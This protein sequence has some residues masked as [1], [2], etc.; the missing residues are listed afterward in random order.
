MILYYFIHIDQTKNNFKIQLC[1]LYLFSVWRYD[2]PYEMV[3][4]RRHGVNLV[5]LGY[6]YRRKASFTNTVNW[7]CSS[8]TQHGGRITFCPARCVTNADGAIKLSRRWHDHGPIYP[9]RKLHNWNDVSGQPGMFGDQVELV[10]QT[11]TESCYEL[12]QINE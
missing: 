10:K 11:E 12:T 7:V 2:K 4:N 9:I 6:M 3:T 1:G 5:Y 8:K